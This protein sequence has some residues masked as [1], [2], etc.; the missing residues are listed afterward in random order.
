MELSQDAVGFLVCGS[1]KKLC[2]L[3]GVFSCD[4]VN[5]FAQVRNFV[6]PICSTFCRTIIVFD[7]I[8]V[9]TCL[10]TVLCLFHAME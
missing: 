5:Y 3:G 1:Q 7:E 4:S 8:L 10:V 9:G 2:S 6:L